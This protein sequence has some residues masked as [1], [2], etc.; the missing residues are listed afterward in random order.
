MDISMKQKQTYR[1][2]DEICGCQ[3]GKFSR[4]VRTRSLGLLDANYYI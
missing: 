1:Y 3:A 4:K 2:R